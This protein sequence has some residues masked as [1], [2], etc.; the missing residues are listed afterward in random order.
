MI[1]YLFSRKGSV[2]PI[3]I[4]IFYTD[5]A[6]IS[7]EAHATLPLKLNFMI[8]AVGKSMKIKI[9]RRGLILKRSR[10]YSDRQ[11]LEN[12]TETRITYLISR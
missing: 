12:L 9:E 2:C 3:W 4:F 11:S 7:G 8:F 6:R 10:G 5:Q 1:K